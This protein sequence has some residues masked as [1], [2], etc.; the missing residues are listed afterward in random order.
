MVNI[1]GRAAKAKPLKWS[2]VKPS[3]GHLG[4]KSD[5]LTIRP[6]LPPK[7]HSLTQIRTWAWER[8]ILA[9]RSPGNTFSLFL[10]ICDLQRASTPF[11]VEFASSPCVSPTIQK[12]SVGEMETLEML[13]YVCKSQY[14]EGWEKT[15]RATP[16]H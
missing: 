7:L 8:W 15:L 11:W 4:N 12:H 10:G 13:M 14:G 2:N 16:N 1:P 9:T 5:F 3:M 6:Q